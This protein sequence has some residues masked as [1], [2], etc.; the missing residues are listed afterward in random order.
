ME[1]LMGLQSQLDKEDIMNRAVMAV[2]QN[3]VEVMKEN[4]HIYSDFVFERAMD[5][6]LRPVD[7]QIIDELGKEKEGKKGLMHNYAKVKL[8][9]KI[10]GIKNIV[11]NT[12]TFS[13]KIEG[14]NLLSAM[15]ENMGPHF[16]KYAEHMIKIIKELILIKYSK[17][18]RGNMVDC[19][20]F[21]VSS[22]TNQEQK[23]AILSQIEG[24]LDSALEKAIKFRDHDDV[25]SITE[26]LS[27][28][29]P[30]MDERMKQALPLKMKAV[31][32]MVSSLV[33]DIEKIY[34]EKDMDDDLTEEM[35]NEIE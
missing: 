7:V 10:D 18:M 31:M 15:A 34:S 30:S 25:C 17:E 21:L 2:Y 9:L 4:F 29:M 3:V 26:A 28:M 22:G 24:S 1:S 16:L 35:N 6:A 27:I 14:T 33:G 11:L 8:D 12:D 20:K 13:Q 19:C 32:G 23:Y 5:A